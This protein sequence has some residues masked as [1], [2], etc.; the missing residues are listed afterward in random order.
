LLR[1]QQLGLENEHRGFARFVDLGA[2]VKGRLRD[3]G[4]WVGEILSSVKSEADFG[5][6]LGPNFT[7]DRLDWPEHDED[8]GDDDG[9]DECGEEE[10][11]Q[12]DDRKS[13]DD[14]DAPIVDLEDERLQGIDERDMAKGKEESGECPVPCSANSETIDWVG[15][16][17]DGELIARFK[18]LRKRFRSIRET[19][20]LEEGT[21]S[22]TFL[23]IDDTCA[24]SLSEAQ[25]IDSAWA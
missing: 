7:L 6:T 20:G 10:E 21:L 12:D 9:D 19:G 8:D 2:A 1:E 11:G 14:R 25:R 16:E 22:N 13:E 18:M 17:D 4:W 23:A 24:F 3:Y 5:E 15:D